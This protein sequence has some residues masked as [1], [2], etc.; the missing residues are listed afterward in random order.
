MKI[1]SRRE[2]LK[3]KLIQGIKRYLTINLVFLILLFLVRIYEFFYLKHAITFPSG[4]LR[5]E[6][7]GFGY[8]VLM[9][10]NLAA[11][12]ILPYLILFLISNRIANFL[13]GLM[14]AL[15]ILAEIA[16]IQYLG[17]TSLMLG[18]DLFGYSFNEI[19]DI[20]SAGGALSIAT[21]LPVCIVVASMVLLL[22]YSKLVKT[23]IGFALL[24]AVLC[25]VSL[26]FRDYTKPEAVKFKSE[27]AFN[28]VSNKAF[29]IFS[30]TFKKVYPDENT[31]E[32]LFSYFYTGVSSPGKSF[33]FVNSE[34]PFLRK[35]ETPD[36]LGKYFNIGKEKPNLVFIIVESLGRAYSGEG[37]YLKSFTPFLDSLE[38]QSLYW[39]NVLSTAGRTFEVLP[40]VFGSMPYG[41]S[42]F[43]D[44]DT[45]MPEGMSLISLLKERGYESRFFY[46][47]DATFDN[48]KMFLTRQHIDYIMDE[49]SFG[50]EY[51]KLPAISAGYFTW[52]Y[53]EKDIFKKSFEILANAGSKPRLDIYLTLAMHDPYRIPDQE[54]Y[55]G[56]V[57]ERLSS[58]NFNEAQKK[59]YRK[60]ILNY[61]TMLYFNDALRN[62]FDQYKKRE[63]FKNTIFFITGD[64]RMSS[65]PIS[66]QIDRF[67]VPLV[68]YSPMLKTVAKFSSVVSHLDF[69]PS[70]VAF[71]K[72]NYGMSFPSDVPWLGKGLDSV[73]T[74]RSTMSVPFIRTKNEIIDYIDRDYFIVNDQLFKVSENM[75]LDKITDQKKITEIQRKF[76]KFKTDNLNACLNNKLIPDSLKFK[77]KP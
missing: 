25:I 36:I 32:S 1:I 10:F 11:Y 77:A 68:I 30:A 52:G 3:N 43:A 31:E 35:D 49:S 47:G 48:M 55:N 14:I 38:N 44:L 57:E 59:E 39:E 61:S 70:V 51:K 65:P 75:G 9:L 33:N 12:F 42:G 26:L 45:A 66:T 19:I 62:F 67:H 71:L 18:A 7:L 58:F 46:G 4:S 34:Y 56:K 6:M 13:F 54:Y 64:H 8:D 5:L 41:K 16:L 23:K 63:D 76:E 17:T 69:T 15:F 2:V 27:M 72:R 20:I 21:L 37:A 28:L 73:K 74:F 22:I 29:H 53:G 50:Q 24:F 60:Y 40:S